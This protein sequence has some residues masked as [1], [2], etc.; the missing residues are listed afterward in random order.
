[1]IL[2]TVM[3]KIIQG[4]ETMNNQEY[5]LSR[6]DEY[7]KINSQIRKLNFELSKIVG[8]IKSTFENEINSILLSI[9]GTQKINSRKINYKY[10]ISFYID[11]IYIEIDFGSYLMNKYSEKYKDKL[12]RRRKPNLQYGIY[13]YFNENK[14]ST[15]LY[16]I[17][18]K[19]TFNNSELY[20]SF[21]NIVSYLESKIISNRLSLDDIKQ[22]LLILKQTLDNFET[23][24]IAEKLD[25]NNN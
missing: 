21:L 14:Y 11:S 4:V 5:Y 2:V 3:V 8:E 20:Q 23:F 19:N 16:K 17:G 10:S 22:N 24:Y 6:I 25:T 1:M 18:W 7:K 15:M 9:F 12:N 13:Y